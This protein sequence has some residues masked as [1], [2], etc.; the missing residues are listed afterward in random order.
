MDYPRNILDLTH[1][2][3]EK[4]L[5]DCIYPWQALEK[6]GDFI[7]AIGALLEE[8]GY[9]QILPSVW[10]HKNAKVD[11]TAKILAPCIIGENTELRQCAYIRGPALIGC[12]C[13]VGNSSEIKNSILFDGVQT[14]HFN[15]VGDSILGYKAHLGAG[16]ITSNVKGDGTFV[17][18]KDGT[19]ALNTGRR[20]FGALLG[21]CAEIGCNSVLNPGTVIG[22]NTRV[23]PLC[24]VRGVIPSDSIYKGYNNIVKDR[25]AR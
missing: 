24:S 15:Y 19:Y 2:K 3:A 9:V 17:T 18:V 13:V 14:P 16:A 23:Y 5:T 6:L 22:R 25:G 12:D 4:L 7:V 10:V 8:D 1:T 21:D 11:K 20:K